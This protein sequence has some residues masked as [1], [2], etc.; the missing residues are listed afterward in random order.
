MLGVRGRIHPVTLQDVHLAVRF[1]D[2]TEVIGEK[3]I[4]ISDK[5]P[6]ARTHNIDQNIVDAWLVGADGDINPRARE[7]ILNAHYIVI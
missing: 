7:A 4:D 5:N 6:G 2:G 1:A 3:N